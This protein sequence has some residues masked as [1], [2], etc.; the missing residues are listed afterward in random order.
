MVRTTALKREELINDI[1]QG[2]KKYK[3][4]YGAVFISLIILVIYSHLNFKLDNEIINLTQE[5]N[6]LI[7]T[8]FKLKKDLAVVSSPNKISNEAKKEGKMKSVDYR[9]VKFLEV[10]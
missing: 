5:K 7:A 6:Y 2:L 1:L 4:Y 9:Q 8:N 3:L 10:K